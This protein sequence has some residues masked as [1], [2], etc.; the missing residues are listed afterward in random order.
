MDIDALLLLSIVITL[1]YFLFIELFSVLFRLTGLSKSKAKF[2]VI[3]LLTNSGFTTQEAELIVSNRY[4]RK[5]ASFTM[6]FGYLLTVAVISMLVNVFMTLSTSASQDIWKFVIL[7]AA[8]IVFLFVFSK[9]KFVEKF[10]RKITEKIA[11]KFLF[12][13]KTNVIEVLDNYD[14]NVIAEVFITYLPKICDGVTLAQNQIKLLHG[15]QVLAIK[16]NG[17]IKTGING[18]DQIMAGDL[19]VVFGES[20]NIKNVFLK[21]DHSDEIKE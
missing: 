20:K 13:K 17:H 10:A 2:Q 11:I 1:V 5:L 14:Q 8:F 21:L 16:R 4:R 3:S 6:F 9:I 15:I 18:D 7:L 19:V 12:G